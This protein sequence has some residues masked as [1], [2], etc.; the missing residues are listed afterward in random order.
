MMT[1]SSEVF[2][3]DIV[4]PE[5]V[6]DLNNHVNNVVYVQWMQDVAVRHSR[7]TGGTEAARQAGGT[8]VARSHRIEYRKPAFVGDHIRL[9]TWV[10]GFRKARSWRKYEFWRL[11]DETLLAQGETEWVFVDTATG[12]PRPVPATV[13]GCFVVVES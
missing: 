8:W 11:G 3:Y 12:R 2:H 5:A 10:S 1:N 7:S 4:V 9:A 6:I 13:A